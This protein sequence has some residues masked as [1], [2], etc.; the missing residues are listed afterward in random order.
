MNKNTPV[1]VFNWSMRTFPHESVSQLSNLARAITTDIFLGQVEDPPVPYVRH[2]YRERFVQ[3]PTMR[4]HDGKEMK[5]K[6]G[7]IITIRTLSG[8]VM[9]RW[10]I[11]TNAPSFSIPLAV[12]TLAQLKV[13]HQTVVQMLVHMNSD[14]PD[15]S[16][17]LILDI[18]GCVHKR[19]THTRKQQ[20]TL[21]LMIK[22]NTSGGMMTH[23]ERPRDLTV[24]AKRHM[25]MQKKEEDSRN[26]S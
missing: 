19:E 6:K 5:F 15:P 12:F 18:S 26:G 1:V 16:P 14:T 4:D 25:P 21:H 17:Y 23:I 2:I 7:T 10:K 24:E 8:R 3:A 22:I 11:E 9:R 13:F 20:K